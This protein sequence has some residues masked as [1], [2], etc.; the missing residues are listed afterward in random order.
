MRGVT[1]TPGVRRGVV[2]YYSALPVLRPTL[3]LP[4]FRPVLSLCVLHGLPLHVVG[5]IR[6]AALQRYDIGQPRSRGRPQPSRRW[7]GKAENADMRAVRR[8]YAE[9]CRLVSVRT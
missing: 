2:R 6:A 5:R 7:R 9:S 8:N 1:L 4:L 3:T